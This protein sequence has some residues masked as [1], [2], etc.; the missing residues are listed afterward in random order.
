MGWGGGGRGCVCV[1]IL[2]VTLNRKHER[3][4]K[5][6]KE[7]S[8]SDVFAP[9]SFPVS[10]IIFYTRTSIQLFLYALYLTIFEEA[11]RRGITLMRGKE[12][13]VKRG[14]ARSVE[15]NNEDARLADIQDIR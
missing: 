2:A 12:D 13:D 1:R 15:L 10:I 14:V 4:E 9:H 3:E 11:Q 7:E 5:C 6:P 8:G